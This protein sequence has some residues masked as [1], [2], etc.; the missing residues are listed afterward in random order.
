MGGVMLCTAFIWWAESPQASLAGTSGEA[1][2]AAVRPRNT[3]PPG[4]Y[5]GLY[6]GDTQVLPLSHHRVSF[7]LEVATPMYLLAASQLVTV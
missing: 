5:G 4:Q 6:Q 1:F 7:S 3:F 2:V